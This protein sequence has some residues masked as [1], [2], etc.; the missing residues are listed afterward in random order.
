MKCEGCPM[1]DGG[2]LRGRSKRLE[3][4]ADMEEAEEIEKRK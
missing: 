3:A 2:C 4:M 1:V